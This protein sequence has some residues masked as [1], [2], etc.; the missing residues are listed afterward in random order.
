MNWA[1]ILNYGGY[2]D[3]RLPTKDELASFAKR[4]G[5]RPSQ[6]FNANGFSNVQAGWYWSSTTYEHN[7]NFAWS[8]SMESGGVGKGNEFHSYY[9]WAVRSGQ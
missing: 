3:W 7:D 4:G 6:Y 1:K 8:V 9:V 5:N 2:N